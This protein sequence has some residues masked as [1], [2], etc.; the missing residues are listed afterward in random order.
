MPPK[1]GSHEYYKLRLSEAKNSY[2]R[3]SKTTTVNIPKFLFEEFQRLK[4]QEGMKTKLSAIL[5]ISML[6]SLYGQHDFV[7]PLDALED[8]F[9]NYQGLNNTKTEVAQTVVE[10]IQKKYNLPQQ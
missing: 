1:K 8:A 2:T 9:E 6:F 7:D 4:K 10:L 5:S 3:N